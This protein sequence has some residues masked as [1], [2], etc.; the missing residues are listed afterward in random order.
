MPESREYLEDPEIV[1]DS[2]LLG[3]FTFFILL[4]L[5]FFVFNVEGFWAGIISFTCGFLIASIYSVWKNLQR[6]EFNRD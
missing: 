3:I 6:K 5:L 2:A 1:G 4:V